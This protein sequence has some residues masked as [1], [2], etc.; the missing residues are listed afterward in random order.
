MF[1]EQLKS[2]AAFSVLFFQGVIDETTD[3]DVKRY[4]FS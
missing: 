4:S 2:E 1:C 3:N